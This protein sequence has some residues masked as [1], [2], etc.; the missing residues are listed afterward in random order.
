MKVE[1]LIEELYILREREKYYRSL[2]HEIRTPLGT[3]K[4]YIYIVTEEMKKYGGGRRKTDVALENL[5]AIYEE[6]KRIEETIDEFSFGGGFNWNGREI[7]ILEEEARFMENIYRKIAES[8]GVAFGVA[9]GNGR[10]PLS[11]SRSSLRQVLSNLVSNACDAT[12]SGGW[13]EVR[14]KSDGKLAR[15]EVEDSGGGLSSDLRGRLFEEPVPSKKG[16]GRGFGLWICR[17]IVDAAGGEIAY[18]EG[19]EGAIFR[20][21][22]PVEGES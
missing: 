21:I 2:L 16:E 5:R 18:E 15:I 19:N 17:N 22:I 10:T 12:S 14:A 9:V 13:I 8:K 20:V 11:I 1:K 4:N 6:V 7:A 3:I